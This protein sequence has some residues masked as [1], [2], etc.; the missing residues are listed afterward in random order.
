MFSALLAIGC[1]SSAPSPAAEP[2]RDIEPAPPPPPEA[3]RPDLRTIAEQEQV[4]LSERHHRLALSWFNKG[5]FDK[6]KAEARL[7][8]QAWPENLAARKLLNEIHGIVAG[9]PPGQTAAEW[10]VR[11]AHV[12]VEQ[13]QIEI[14]A[15][16]LHGERMLNAKMYESALRE[17]ENAQFKI[18]TI[19][20]DVKAMNELLPKVRALI[21]R[22]KSS[23][24]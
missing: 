11:T 19:P 2:R 20:Y 23:I 13:A 15:H 22:A 21:A 3:A 1:A 4:F 6:A 7:A 8:V 5:D 18:L 10:E 9:G 17:F 16:I 12:R 14:T 24:R